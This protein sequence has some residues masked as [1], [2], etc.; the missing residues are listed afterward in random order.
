MYA[1]NQQQPMY[2]SIHSTSYHWDHHLR[3]MYAYFIDLDHL[4]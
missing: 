1:N 3:G 2:G 4:F